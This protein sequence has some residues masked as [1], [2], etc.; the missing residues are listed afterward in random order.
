VSRFDPA[1]PGP[2]NPYVRGR[3]L[4][5]SAAALVCGLTGLAGA[6]AAAGPSVALGPDGETAPVYSYANAIRERVW[7][8]VPGVDQDANGVAD[9]VA[10]DIVRPAE[11]ATSLKVPAIIVPSPYLTSIGITSLGQVIHTTGAAPDF[12]PG[13]YDNYFVPR[14]YAVILAQSNG[15]GWSTGCPLHG[16]PGD[17]A[18]VR[19]VI[20]WLQGVVGVSG[21]DASAGGN[22]VT[23]GWDNGK[24]A[25][26]GKSYDGTLA[27]GVAAT[28]VQGLTTIVPESAIS[29]WYLYSRS[30]GVRFNASHYPASLSNSIT[31]DATATKLGVVPPSHN[32][33]C[34]NTRTQMNVDDGDATGDENAFWQA[35]NYNTTVAQV[36]ASVF[37]SFGLNDDNVKFDHMSTWWAGLAANNVPRKLWLSQEGHVDP[38]DYRRDDWVDTLHRWFDYWLLDVPNGVMSEPRVTIERSTD[39]WEND[40]DWP[41]PGTSPVSVFLNGTAAGSAGTFGALA[42]GGSTATLSFLDFKTQTETAT[43]STPDGSQ[44]NRLTFLS[45]VL[46]KDLHISGVPKIELH[47]SLSTPGGN[48]GA[49]LVDY[50]AAPFTRPTRSNDG[51]VNKTPLEQDCRFGDS[52]AADSSCYPVRVKPTAA[53]SQWLVSNGVLDAQ[54][55]DSLTLPAPLIPAMSYTFGF[56]LIG[57]DY[58]FPA[59]HRVGVVVVSSYKD[60]GGFSTVNAPDTPTVTIDT[61]LSKVELP[62][63]GGA[64]AARASTLFLDTVAPTLTLPSPPTVEAAGPVTGV[65]FSPSASDNLDDS[66]VV[67]CAPASGAAF[68]VGTTTVSCTATDLSGN[69]SSGSFAVT[70]VDTT[71]PKLTLPAPVTVEATGP[72]GVAVT[73][74]ASASDLVDASP[75]VA[76]SAGSGSTF[77]LGATTVTCTAKDAAGNTASGSFTVTVADTTSPKLTG[78]RP[79][80][81]NATSAKGVKVTFRA[82][83]ADTVDTTPLVSCKPASGAVFKIGRTLVSCSATDDAANTTT[84][85]FTIVVAGAADQ[86]KA[87]R[88]KLVKGKNGK[89]LARRV[90]AVR[91]VLGKRGK[92][93]KA[94]AQL[95]RVVPASRRADVARIQRVVGC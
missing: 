11:T 86:L 60:Y 43:I 41:L 51:I 85:R 72:S 1:A 52:T 31:N 82:T 46:R 13:W 40:A 21:F 29:D 78:L 70:V 58:V 80:T 64:T 88:A 27:N 38:F 10:L 73:Y 59:G 68:P 95:K 6:A 44:A 3:G 22:A 57:N 37:A 84:S 83:A 16:G 47:G 24:A 92:A 71:A 2:D 32:V 19:A 36:H 89:A 90:D 23:A 4:V 61:H 30:N 87:L 25:M 39:V 91:A 26:I 28:G 65:S 35:R 67:S 17:I 5:A 15:T 20:D 76:C 75:A 94:L 66:P 79:I 54:N 69:T 14:G 81:V 50:S 55:R 9:R 56:P 48:L 12:F 62:I 45:P 7:V 8:Q 34:A 74:A 42:N 93:C 77:A 18:S 53:V 63:V 33:P 49:V